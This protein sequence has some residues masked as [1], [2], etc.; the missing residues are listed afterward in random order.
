[1][2]ILRTWENVTPSGEVEKLPEDGS[3]VLDN[4]HNDDLEHFFANELDATYEIK[5]N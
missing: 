5:L 2:R 3:Y 1:M 4:T